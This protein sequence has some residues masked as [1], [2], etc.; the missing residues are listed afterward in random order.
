MNLQGQ[1]WGEVVIRK[2]KPTAAASSSDQAVNQARRQGDQVDINH[3]YGGGQNKSIGTGKDAAKLD[4]ETEETHHERVPSELKKRISQARLEKKL[5]QAQLAQQIN[6][7]PSVIN[8][9]E[10]G[11][12][13]PNPQVLS[14]MSKVLGVQLSQ[15]SIAKK[16]TS[17]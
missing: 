3:K 6:E 7:K 5:T 13:I 4:R 1:D 16:K 10:S 9:Y 17:S 8:E 12:A 14:K 2:K 11:K 15:K